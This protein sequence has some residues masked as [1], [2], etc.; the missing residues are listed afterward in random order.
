MSLVSYRAR[1]PRN[2]LVD[3]RGNRTPG[4]VSL[5]C[6]CAT[7]LAFWLPGYLIPAQAHRQAPSG[8]CRMSAVFASCSSHVA[9][10]P[11]QVPMGVWNPS[12]CRRT[13]AA[14]ARAGALNCITGLALMRFARFLRGQLA[15]SACSLK[16][17]VAVE[18]CRAQKGILDSPS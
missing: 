8:L 16:P 10:R 14:R 13:Q 11:T 6:Q 7:C 4:P 2:K 3:S 18:T 5:Q 1:R 15:S 12:C 9:F 17:S